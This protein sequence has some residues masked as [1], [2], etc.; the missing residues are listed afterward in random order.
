MEKMYKDENLRFLKQDQW[1][2]D[3]KDQEEVSAIET[4][5]EASVAVIEAA[6]LIAEEDS[7]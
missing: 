6:D 7:N 4:E 5:E 3:Q 2:R 1:K